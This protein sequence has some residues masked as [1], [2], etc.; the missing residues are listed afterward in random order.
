MNNPKELQGRFVWLNAFFRSY[1]SFKAMSEICAQLDQPL[2]DL[3]PFTHFH[4]VLLYDTVINWCKIFGVNSEDCHWKHVVKDHDQFREY[5]FDHLG[6]S[7]EEFSEYHASVIEFRNKWVVHYDP[8]YNYN[9]VP[10]LETA[11]EST[12]ILHSYLREYS[13]EN[14]QYDGPRSMVEFGKKVAQVMVSKL[15]ATANIGVVKNV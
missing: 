10:E 5:L 7:Q 6:I 3:Y 12:K 11:H 1:Y 4:N 13:H 2:G 14:I 8:N 15:N 9:V